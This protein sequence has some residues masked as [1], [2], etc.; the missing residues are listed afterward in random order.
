MAM[1]YS[2]GFSLDNLRQNLFSRQKSFC[3]QMHEEVEAGAEQIMAKSQSNSPVDTYNLEEA[4]HIT[5]TMTE[6]DHVRFT[7]EVSGPGYGSDDPRDVSNYAME[8]HENYENMGSGGHP[9]PGSKS[10]AKQAA[11]HEVGS[12]FLERAI[13]T[14]KP[15]VINKVRKAV[16][17]NWTNKKGK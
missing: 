10:A 4:H 17:A 15:E 1:R 11:G 8:V 13:E 14:E 2:S 3:K 6:A 9:K 7:V 16:K 12:K 5:K